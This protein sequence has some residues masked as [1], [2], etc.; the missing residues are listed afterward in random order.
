MNNEKLFNRIFEEYEASTSGGEDGPWSELESEISSVKSGKEMKATINGK[1]DF[2]YNDGG[3]GPIP[4]SGLNRKE[5]EAIYSKSG[6]ILEENQFIKE[7]NA[8][9]TSFRVD[10]IIKKGIEEGWSDNKI[11]NKIFSSEKAKMEIDP[12]RVKI[13]IAKKRNNLMESQLR[14]MMARCDICE[15]TFDSHDGG[16]IIDDITYCPDCYDERELDEEMPT[17]TKSNK[18]IERRQPKGKV[19]PVLRES[20][21]NFELRKRLIENKII[22]KS[23]LDLLEDFE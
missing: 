23:D 15:R 8:Y 11:M 16:D 21:K 9:V 5:Y 20:I 12:E 13:H 18:L 2:E 7:S 4:R 3:N 1:P 19:S 6:D 10:K 22:N 14:E 17:H